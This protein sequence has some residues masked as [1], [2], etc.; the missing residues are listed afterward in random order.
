MNIFACY[1][2]IM[3]NGRKKNAQAKK[4]D[5]L[6]N[7]NQLIWNVNGWQKMRGLNENSC[8]RLVSFLIHF[9]LTYGE[10]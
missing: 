9:N 1:I 5:Y 8:G 10:I 6:Y 7:A 2:W 3:M 4:N